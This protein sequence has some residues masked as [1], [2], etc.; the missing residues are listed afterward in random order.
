MHHLRRLCRGSALAEP[1]GVRAP[2]CIPGLLL[3]AGNTGRL[4]LLCG[5]AYA[6]HSGAYVGR[7][8]MF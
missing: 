3:L 2:L 5:L 6:G 1:A 8:S 4:L 7:E